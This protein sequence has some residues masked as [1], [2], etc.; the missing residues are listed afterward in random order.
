M[1]VT[2]VYYACMHAALEQSFPISAQVTCNLAH[3]TFGQCN[4][5]PLFFCGCNVIPFEKLTGIE[6]KQR[7]ALSP[8]DIPNVSRP[9]SYVHAVIS[10]AHRVSADTAKLHDST[11]PAYLNCTLPGAIA[12][13]PSH[14][15]RLRPVRSRFGEAKLLSRTPRPTLLA[16]P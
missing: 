10:A 5:R 16:T 4:T 3:V 13:S 1:V 11:L 6:V 15:K 12:V 7:K 14:L 9:F 8:S 2:S